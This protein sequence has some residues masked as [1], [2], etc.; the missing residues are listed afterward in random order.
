MKRGLTDNYLNWIP[1]DVLLYI[2]LMLELPDII[3]L[4]TTCSKYN[5]KIAKCPIFWKNKL[6]WD[7]PNYKKF[8][9]KM[10]YR[11]KYD[12]IYGLFKLKQPMNLYGAL[13][14]SLLDIS[15]ITWLSLPDEGLTTLPKEIGNLREL[16]YLNL[17]LNQL[18]ILPNKI[19]N[20]RKLRFLN[21]HNNQ[22]SALPKEIGNLQQLEYLN[23]SNNQLTKVPKEIGN[24]YQLHYLRLNDNKLTELPKEIGNLCR[25]QSFSLSGNQITKLPKEIDIF[26]Y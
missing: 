5:E 13:Y 21:L 10:S 17:S 25:L 19:G 3:S 6:N 1:K 22:L 20:L 9:L 11:H 4:C 15:R 23:L 14:G 7:F 24:L 12:Y 2:S 8:N 16:K 26:I 18:T